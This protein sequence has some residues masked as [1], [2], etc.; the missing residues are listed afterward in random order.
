[1]ASGSYVLLKSKFCLNKNKTLTVSPFHLSEG[2]ITVARAN[3]I[4]P[5]GNTEQHQAHNSM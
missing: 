2:W 3:Y 1:M 5:M 4:L